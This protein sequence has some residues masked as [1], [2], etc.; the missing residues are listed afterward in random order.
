MQNGMQIVEQLNQPLMLG[1]QGKP[2]SPDGKTITPPVNHGLQMMSMGLL[3][4]NQAAT[5]WRGPM[6]SKA[7]ME[8]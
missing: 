6:A 7:L 5:I 2:P 1:I 4:E 8:T 3:V